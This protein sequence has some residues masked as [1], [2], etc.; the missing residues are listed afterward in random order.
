[1]SVFHLH[2]LRSEHEVKHAWKAAQW[3]KLA[4]AC[5]RED[6][7]RILLDLN[8]PIRV[9]WQTMATRSGISSLYLCFVHGFV[10]LKKLSELFYLF[11]W[12]LWNWTVIWINICTMP[13]QHIN[14]PLYLLK[15]ILRLTCHLKVYAYKP[16][17][18]TH[19]SY[20]RLAS[21]WL[22]SENFSLEISQIREFT[23]FLC[24][25]VWF[26][27][28]NLFDKIILLVV[29]LLIFCAVS[30]ELHEELH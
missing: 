11:L 23:Q 10:T 5:A 25:H 15:K 22:E 24:I 30:V 27:I 2:K 4:Q 16:Y 8:I 17:T 20:N 9:Q 18:E 19:N 13:C 6:H 14:L 1:M 28:P 29:E 21:M 12:I 26:E 3:A 7:R